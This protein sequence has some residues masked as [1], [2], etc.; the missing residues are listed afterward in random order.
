MEEHSS[1]RFFL[2]R[3][4]AEWHLPQGAPTSP[5]LAN[6]AAFAL[7]VRLS[8]IAQARGLEYSRYADDLVFSGPRISV[9]PLLQQVNS[10]ARSEKFRLNV[11]K[12]RVMYA[13][14]QQRVT[15]VVVNQKPN[16]SREEFDAL[17]ALLHRCAL[18]GPIS[19]STGPL[20]EFRATLQG[21]ISW[22]AQLSPARGA[23][24]QQKFDALDW[25]E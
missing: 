15:G 13:H 11:A 3:R 16:I 18:R 12:T 23:K 5:A 2:Q 19:Q 24:L 25:R 1:E 10:I 4:L 20:S 9:G 6:L 7:D 14:E 17:K 22:V 21:K 8:A